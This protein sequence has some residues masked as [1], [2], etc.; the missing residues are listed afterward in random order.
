MG[1]LANETKVYTI[2]SPHGVDW[3]NGKIAHVIFLFAINKDD[4]EE[5]MSLY[6]LFVTFMNGKAVDTILGCHSYDE[7]QY[8]AKEC[9]FNRKKKIGK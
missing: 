8:V 2:I 4:Y 6:D 9:W 7:F 3:G 5:A 1:L